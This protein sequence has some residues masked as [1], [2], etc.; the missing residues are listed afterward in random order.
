M[1]RICYLLFVGFEMFIQPAN[2]SSIWTK[3]KET[4]DLLCNIY[5]I[6]NCKL[7][8]F[9]ISILESVYDMKNNLCLFER[10]F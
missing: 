1:A 4:R 10:P 2:K 8:E 3:L 5:L 7:L 6:T 9:L